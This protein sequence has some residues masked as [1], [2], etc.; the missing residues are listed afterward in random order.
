M[1]DRVKLME[2]QVLELEVAEVKLQVLELKAAEMKV[3]GSN[4]R[5]QK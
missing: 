3:Q 4:P 5:Q 2:F 1:S